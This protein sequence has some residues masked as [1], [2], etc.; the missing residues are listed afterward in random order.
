M[1]LSQI[2]KTRSTVIAVQWL[3][4]QEFYKSCIEY[5]YIK[6]RALIKRLGFIQK[7][8]NAFGCTSVA[9][10]RRFG[11]EVLLSELLEFQSE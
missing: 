10:A 7:D 5:V 3:N 9:Q 6:D 1:H 2:L 8:V 4:P 11:K